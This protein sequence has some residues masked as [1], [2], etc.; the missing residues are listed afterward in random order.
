VDSLSNS[1]RIYGVLKAKFAL[2]EILDSINIC[3]FNGLAEM[4]EPGYKYKN[5]KP[6]MEIPGQQ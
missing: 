6:G 1:T 3:F 4:L 2:I 5:K